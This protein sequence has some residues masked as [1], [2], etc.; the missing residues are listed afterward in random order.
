MVF[1]LWAVGSIAVCNG[2]VGA[3]APLG[4]IEL[5]GHAAKLLF[6][7]IYAAVIILGQAANLPQREPEK[8]VVKINNVSIRV[9]GEVGKPACG[10]F[11]GG[12]VGH[13]RFSFGRAA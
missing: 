1:F 4:L 3:E 6:V 8:N 9:A 2:L 5:G 11:F 13:F 7:L 12:H 10:K